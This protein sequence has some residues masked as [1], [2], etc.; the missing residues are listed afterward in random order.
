MLRMDITVFIGLHSMRPPSGG[1]GAEPLFKFLSITI[2]AYKCAIYL[3]NF[4]GTSISTIFFL[5]FITYF[6]VI[7]GFA[8]MVAIK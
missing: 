7:V 5:T 6:Y 8:A 4:L 3:Y 2:S 1:V